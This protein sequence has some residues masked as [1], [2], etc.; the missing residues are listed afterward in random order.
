MAQYQFNSLTGPGSPNSGTTGL[1]NNG[2]AVGWIVDLTTGMETSCIWSNKAWSNPNILGSNLKLWRINDSGQI[3]DEL[4]GVVRNLQGAQ[5]VDLTPALGKGNSIVLF[6]I[7]NASVVVGAPFVPSA[8]ADPSIGTAYFGPQA[9]VYDLNTTLPAAINPNPVWINPLPGLHSAEASS[10]NMVLG[11][12]IG[13]SENHSFRYF[14]SGTRKGQMDDLGVCALVDIN[15][16]GIAVGCKLDSQGNPTI[17]IWVDCTQT[18]PQHNA[19][20]LPPGNIVGQ[21][22]AIN[23]HGT[24]VGYYGVD[25]GESVAFVSYKDFAHG[26]AQD[27]NNLVDTPGWHLSHAWDI[28]EAGDISGTALAINPNSQNPHSGILT[29]YILQ[30]VV[31]RPPSPILGSLLLLLGEGVQEGASGKGY[32]PLGPP[33]PIGPSGPARWSNLSATER[34][35][36]LGLATSNLAQLFS[37]PAT[38]QQIQMA[39]LEA[40]STALARQQR[41]LST[42]RVTLPSSARAILE[43]N[44]RSLA[45]K[46]A[47]KPGKP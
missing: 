1:N 7:N 10:A 18:H 23:S 5:L 29:G 11:L 8:P 13:F 4:T 16:A 19:I 41:R 37:N 30:A 20:N 15:D 24:I 17:P 40:S 36:L 26:D 3:T 25:A 33:V 32:P 12:V 21:A 31:V 28:N 9:L 22:W 6:G 39:A 14:L 45:P 35:V 34:E 42:H 38:R 47:I 44:Q 2:D 46:R 27:L 43:R